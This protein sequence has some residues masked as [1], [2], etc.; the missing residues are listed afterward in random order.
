M[1]LYSSKYTMFP[2]GI[3]FRNI[4]LKSCHQKEKRHQILL[5]IRYALIK[6][7]SEYIFWLWWVA[8]IEPK[9]EILILLCLRKEKYI[10]VAEPFFLLTVV[11]VK[12]HGKRPVVSTDGGTC[13]YLPC[14]K[15]VVGSWIWSIIHLFLLFGEK[16]HHRKTMIMQYIKDRTT[17]S[18]DIIFYAK[19]WRIVNYSM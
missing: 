12:Y 10:V 9:R 18:F 4:I 1:S 16:H 19:E 17:E 5:P 3:G 6:V 8:M 11:R 13:W 15:P 7:G 14:H 2:Y